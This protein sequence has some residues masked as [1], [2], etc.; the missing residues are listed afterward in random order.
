M[1]YKTKLRAYSPLFITIFIIASAVFNVSIAH[2]DVFAKANVGGG[3]GI[4][5]GSSDCK[6]RSASYNK[7][8]AKNVKGDGS[9]G[10]GASFVAYKW[11]VIDKVNGIPSGTW[12]D[13]NGEDAIFITK[14]ANNNVWWLGEV[15]GTPSDNN[16]GGFWMGG[17]AKMGYVV[18][19]AW[20]KGGNEG[21]SVNQESPLNRQAGLLPYGPTMAKGVQLNEYG[22]ADWR[23]NGSID[24]LKV[25]EELNQKNAVKI[26]FATANQ[27]FT[28][29]KNSGYQ[30][31][32]S[33]L[34]HNINDKNGKGVRYFCFDPDSLAG[35]YDFYSRSAYHLSNGTSEW[36]DPGTYPS[37]RRRVTGTLN[38]AKDAPDP[39]INFEQD[40][41]VNL[42]DESLHPDR[43]NIAIGTEYKIS[44]E[45][46]KF[47]TI[48]EGTHYTLEPGAFMDKRGGS[49]A[50]KTATQAATGKDNSW[51]IN[52]DAEPQWEK[53]D[54]YK[55]SW[56]KR[57]HSGGIKVKVPPVP[58]GKLSTSVTICQRIRLREKSISITSEGYPQY[59]S[60]ASSVDSSDYTTMACVT[61][62][63]GEAD[64]DDPGNTGANDLCPN[65]KHTANFGNTSAF[66]SVRN[67]TKSNSWIDTSAGEDT[68]NEQVAVFAKPSDTV[69]FRHALCF[70]AQAVKANPNS[71]NRKTLSSLPRNKFK[72]TAG[73]RESSDNFTQNNK[74]L[75]GGKN[76]I[77]RGSFV[78]LTRG[79]EFP[80]QVSN[81]DI[82][83]SYQFLVQSPN[84][85]SGKTDYSC[86]SMVGLGGNNYIYPGYQIHG[87]SSTNGNCNA[88][89]KVASSDVGKKV[90]QRLD[91][92][93]VK[94]WISRANLSTG[95][96]CG[97]DDNSAYANNEI[98]ASYESAERYSKPENF[99]E[100]IYRC[101]NNGKTCNCNEYGCDTMYDLE[102]RWVYPLG[103]SETEGTTKM[104][105]A[106]VPYN[107]T[108]EVSA[109]IDGNHAY[110]GEK[111]NISSNV[112]VN[113]REN[114]DVNSNEAYAT[115]T[116]NNTKV[117]T[118][119]FIV[120]DNVTIGQAE[121][122][123]QGSDNVADAGD[124]L[125]AYYRSKF[126]ASNINGC[127]EVNNITKTLNSEGN[128]NGGSE[129][130]SPN[131]NI[132]V[133]DIA[134]G[135]K[136]CVATG[137]YPSDS[138]NRPDEMLGPGANDGGV[139]LE[140]NTGKTWNISNATCVTISKKPNFQTW[141]GGVY[142]PANIKTSLS[143]KY[144]SAS[145]N[146]VPTQPRVFG[147]WTEYEAIARGEISGFSSGA[148]LGYIPV[149]EPSPYYGGDYKG[150]NFYC[151]MAPLSIAN[152]KC[153]S[154]NKFGSSNIKSLNSSVLLDRI[155]SRYTSS[156]FEPIDPSEKV[157][158]VNDFKSMKNI[159]DTSN[160]DD[161]SS[162]NSTKYVYSGEN[163]NVGP[164]ITPKQESSASTFN[165]VYVIYSKK[166]INITDNICYYPNRHCMN[167]SGQV[168]AGIEGN[169]PLYY[170]IAELPQIIIIAEGNVNIN[171]NVT[172]IDAWIIAK[173]NNDK[174]GTINTC[175]EFKSGST[176]SSHSDC[177]TQLVV[178]GPIFARQ[179]L[180]NRTAGSDNGSGNSQGYFIYDKNLRDDGSITPAEIFNLRPDSFLWGYAQ[181][182]N[183][184]QAVVTY[185][186]NLAPRY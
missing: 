149:M 148:A 104:A 48:Q 14:N 13:D 65:F 49:C 126:G 71:S 69:Q 64:E 119:A 177:S 116:P 163:I 135:N 73:T 144:V 106:I 117:K 86:E 139:G 173:G 123:T 105:Q 68:S 58:D 127:K 60:S 81:A 23:N 25:K 78:N 28:D 4:G 15:A 150:G 174:G 178:S 159:I 147:S 103:T 17:C 5:T 143:P 11:D 3:S 84:M 146:W 7:C 21:A 10:G 102:D 24:Y 121:T 45:N 1:I 184:N 31:E 179:L 82:K 8:K 112:K 76:N 16:S 22:A 164:F 83:K 26:N 165:S 52:C 120:K 37:G 181:A 167:K 32:F 99:G 109:K 29:I 88:A 129:K 115:I 128:L 85:D 151:S 107:F 183:L 96:Y 36:T 87:M 92:N 94:A 182:Q 79:A 2:I 156:K 43:L 91:W 186:R 40:I 27:I 93:N 133:P 97:C 34:E 140:G 55:A 67:R 169:D 118:I 80:S 170:N 53:S 130:F 122:A 70:G 39:V 110:S 154:D 101:R 152:D 75:F 113:P 153:N 38:I 63:R 47:G 59:H 141:G 100:R 145:F 142:T 18:R 132:I 33:S 157:D 131:K 98:I 172:A 44:G 57:I 77:L 160:T 175:T 108:T 95:G 12:D 6:N 168:L 61:V 89:T 50:P 137:V 134:P 9:W 166:D 74:Y 171:S 30:T 180:L 90:E 111:I 136:F 124:A 54:S 185:T 125:C 41:V 72:I 51:I 155:Y 66:S 114:P 20:E 162:S 138:H 56:V 42:H 35:G 62:V 161:A 46:D 176:A 19:F 158:N